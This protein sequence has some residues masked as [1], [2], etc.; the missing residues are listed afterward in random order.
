M[1]PVRRTEPTNTVSTY[2]WVERV[3]HWAIALLIPTA[4]VLG[5]I[6]H[7]LAYDTDAALARKAL[8]FSLHKSVGL[9]IL[10]VALARIAWALSQ[11]RPRPLHPDRRAETFLA[12][13]VHWLLYGSLVLV[14]MLGWATH[15]AT[16]GFAPIPWPFGQSLPFVP[17]D[18]ALAET[19][20][21]LHMVLSG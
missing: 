9:T 1:T 6:A 17:R 12:G 16:E 11:P 8:L 13:L 20:A 5:V 4:I 2:G 15:A 3:F 14:P 21:T 7:G 18:P 19:L 10:A